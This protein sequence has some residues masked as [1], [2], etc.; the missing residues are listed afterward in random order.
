M[1]PLSKDEQARERQLANL[2]RGDNPAPAANQR[3]L[4]HGAESETALGT[5]R[6]RF[7]AELVEEF[8]HAP[9]RDLRLVAHRLAQVE[10][11]AE[12]VDRKGVIAHQR[13]G[14]VLPAVQTL[15]RL[16]NSIEQR[17]DRLR[18]REASATAPAS[19]LA[20]WQRPQLAAPAET[21]PIDGQLTVDDCIEE[22]S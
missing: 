9:E 3:A 7:L 22:A 10:R 14:T 12:Y 19:I 15:D 16:T 20:G 5:A 1:S 6:E 17:L 11:L 13:R 8:P 18:D 2:K 4:K 21:P